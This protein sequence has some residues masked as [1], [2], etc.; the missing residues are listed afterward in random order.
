[1]P[2]T[3]GSAPVEP[4]RSSRPADVTGATATVIH[5]TTVVTA[6][7]GG[8]IHH[9]AALAVAGGRI[10]ALGP[11]PEVLARH[12][13]AAR[14]DGRGRAVLPGLANAHTHLSRVLDRGIAEDLS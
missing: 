12:P 2:P 11:T 7:A 6:D 8:T 14:I 10:V 13:D 9:D 4:W 5:D 3:L 1:M